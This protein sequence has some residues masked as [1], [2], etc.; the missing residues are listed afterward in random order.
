MLLNIL[1][2][3]QNMSLD[4]LKAKR[5]QIG[6]NTEITL[7]NMNKIADESIRVADVAHNSKTILDDLDREFMLQTGLNG[8]DMKFLFAAVALQL[9]RI[10]LL[11]EITKIEKAGKGV[12][13]KKL[14][15]ND[16]QDDLYYSSLSH[17]LLTSGVPYD[18]TGFF[19][20]ESKEKLLSK[21]ADW[22]NQLDIYMLK[23]KINI[24][25]FITFFTG[26]TYKAG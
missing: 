12:K 2:R 1:V 26:I 5:E 6:R 15:T 3:D 14:N 13:E 8:N 22:D 10:V 23:K 18:A 21:G 17:I 20:E 24:F 25:N 11:N 16:G 4:E 19:I 7:S 9:S